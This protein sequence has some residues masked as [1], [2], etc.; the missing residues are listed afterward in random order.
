[1]DEKLI[2][3]NGEENDTAPKTVSAEAKPTRPYIFYCV[4]TLSVMI[5]TLVFTASE[6]FALF[7]SEGYLGRTLMSKVFGSD[8]A[9]DKSIHEIMLGQSFVDL[10]VGKAETS[11]HEK[12][13]ESGP[14]SDTE[15][16]EVTTPSVSDSNETTAPVPDREEVLPEG[17]KAIIP[18]DLSLFEY[19]LDYIHDSSV[20]TP[21][22]LAADF[23]VSIDIS[24][25]YPIGSP[26]VLIVHT[27]G[28][29]AY[30]KKGQ[31]GYD[32]SKEV[33]RSDNTDE[34]VVALGKRLASGLNA[35]GISTIHCETAFDAEGYTGAYERSGN[36]IKEYLKR[37]PSIQYVIDLHRDAVV[38]SDGELVKPI[39]SSPTGDMAQVM[40][41]VG[42][43]E[44][45]TACENWQRNLALAQKLRKT[46]NSENDR[47]CRPTC[48][49]DSSYNQQYA[50]HSMLI[51]LG[52]A[53]NTLEEAFLAVDAVCRALTDVIKG[54]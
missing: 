10:S 38:T 27:H 4:M 17:F 43:G 50:A 11:E 25:V 14:V 5:F 15:P 49:R 51:E 19:G 7:F 54:D 22:K 46:L 33:A 8:V 39:C 30:S 29:E 23:D 16:A 31:A 42:T 45:Q 32:P 40:F 44:A 52:A 26:L 37:Y 20:L 1:M 35:S 3:A 6:L 28:T 12:E 13:T 2:E 47:L 53:G 24:S 9:S 36:A 48:L 21:D 18:M 34:N 41:V